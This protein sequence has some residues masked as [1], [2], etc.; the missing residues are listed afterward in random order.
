MATVAVETA[1]VRRLVNTA[2]LV[3]TLPSPLDDVG[4]GSFRSIPAS[5]PVT[6]RILQSVGIH[7]V[8]GRTPGRTME[9]VEPVSTRAQQGCPLTE[10]RRIVAFAVLDNDGSGP[11]PPLGAWGPA[12]SRD[13][14]MLAP[15]RV[16]TWK[17]SPTV[18]TAWLGGG[19][20][21][22]AKGPR[23]KCQCRRVGTRECHCLATPPP[24]PNPP[25]PA[26]T[27]II[28]IAIT[29]IVQGRSQ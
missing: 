28:I 14:I 16:A 23:P 25:F 13:P 4:G 8:S 21:G 20:P 19:G 22:G 7:P 18:I 11:R 26:I 17:R 1:V 2:G 10:Q 3:N 15:L 24:P 9:M 5:S 29:I 27:I 12:P 6:V